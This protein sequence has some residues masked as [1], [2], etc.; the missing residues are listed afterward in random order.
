MTRK[1]LTSDENAPDIETAPHEAWVYRLGLSF[2]R[3]GFSAFFQ[4]GWLSRLKKKY[5]A[6]FGERMGEFGS[7]YMP[8]R[9]ERC[10]LRFP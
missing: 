4:C 8:R 6:D 5:K 1:S 7:G 9:L 2:Y 3:F 10:N